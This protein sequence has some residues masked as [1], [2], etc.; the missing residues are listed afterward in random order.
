MTTDILLVGCGNMGFAMLKGWIG[1][2]GMTFHVVEPADALRE[3]AEEAGANT[4]PAAD[5]LPA[6][7]VP[8]LAFLAVKPQVMGDVAPQYQVFAGGKTTFV[9]VAAGVTIGTLTHY[10][11]G[12]TPI[13]RCMPNTPAA[14][15]RGMLVSCTNEAV[16]DSA[17]ALTETLL[18]T[19]GETAWIEDENLMDAV[20]AISGS[21][22]AYV[23]HFIECLAAAARAVGLPDDLAE[24]LALQTVAGAGELAIRSDDPPARLREQV[25]SPGGT[26]AAALTVFMADGA[27]EDLVTKPATAARDRGM[28]LGK[29]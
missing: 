13:I 5:Q 16:S 19:S 26:T 10:L 11:P 12:A 27:L 20:T 29:S 23:F 2:A 18:A 28:E 14:I 24:Q 4:Y 8:D 7:L 6:G 25:T 21:G 1:Q 15:G 22:P 17:K 3:R 9:S